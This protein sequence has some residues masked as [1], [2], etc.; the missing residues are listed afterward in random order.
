MFTVDGAS[1]TFGVMIDGE[2]SDVQ[3]RDD[4]PA[5]PRLA[6]VSGGTLRFAPALHGYLKSVRIYDRA[7]SQREVEESAI[8]D[9]RAEMQRE[10]PSAPAGDCADRGS[11]PDTAT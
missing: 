2:R 11:F 3:A 1:Q 4:S 8:A 9:R 10:L 6:D 7:L 5:Q